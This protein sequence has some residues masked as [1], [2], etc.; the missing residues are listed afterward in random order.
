MAQVQSMCLAV[1]VPLVALDLRVQSAIGG[2]DTEVRRYVGLRLAGRYIGR[3]G[4]LVWL[5][6][7]S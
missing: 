2:S 4:P 3:L 1:N 7:D 5:N 6:A